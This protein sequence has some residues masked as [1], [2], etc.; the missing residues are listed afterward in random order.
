MKTYSCI[1]CNKICNFGYSKQNKFC[2][3][4]CQR[5]AQRHDTYERF[6][7]GELTERSVIRKIL[8]WKNGH[9]CSS[10]NLTEWSNQPIPL[11]L[12]HV[13][14]DAGNNEPLNLRVL[15]PNCHG[16][17]STWKG[18]NKGGGRKARGIKLS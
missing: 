3:N 11:E 10:C 6:L 9:K 12:D 8:V 7:K 18:R 15:C 17:T 5:E 14:G 4:N 13:D 16:I 2:S 1:Q